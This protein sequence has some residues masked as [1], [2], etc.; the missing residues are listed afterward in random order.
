M[1][2]IFGKRMFFLLILAKSLENAHDLPMTLEFQRSQLYHNKRL[3]GTTTCQR[4]ESSA[5]SL[6][7]NKRLQ[8]ATTPDLLDNLMDVCFPTYRGQ[9][10][11]P[12]IR[13]PHS[14]GQS[15]GIP[16]L[17]KGRGG[18][19][20]EVRITSDTA[21]QPVFRPVSGCVRFR[22]IHLTSRKMTC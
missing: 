3:Q 1:R 13:Q 16:L 4:R 15:P 6:Y 12:A 11:K 19:N 7:H 8:R 9:T 20:A 10:W 18:R 22:A 2:F 21:D 5:S 14:P 17:R